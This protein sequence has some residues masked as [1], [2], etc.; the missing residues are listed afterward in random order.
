MRAATRQRDH[1]ERVC[2]RTRTLRCRSLAV[3]IG[4]VELIEAP[5]DQAG[6]SCISEASREL[7]ETRTMS[8]INVVAPRRGGTVSLSFWRVMSTLL[9]AFSG[10]CARQNAIVQDG[11]LIRLFFARRRGVSVERIFSRG[12]E[13]SAS[14]TIPAEKSRSV[15]GYPRCRSLRSDGR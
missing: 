10:V 5:R 3:L 8:D 7:H 1:S 15:S 12:M 11:V 4:H 14:V 13:L 9:A 6:V 2:H